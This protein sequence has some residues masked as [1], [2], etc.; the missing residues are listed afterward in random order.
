MSPYSHLKK[1]SNYA[2]LHHISPQYLHLLVSLGR[3]E[4]VNIDG[5]LL[6]DTQVYPKV[7]QKPTKGAIA[8]A[9]KKVKIAKK[10]R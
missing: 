3:M 4:F 2:K 10:K 1:V 8:Q 6:I 5:Y 7:P 9:L